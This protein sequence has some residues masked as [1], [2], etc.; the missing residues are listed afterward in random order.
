MAVKFLSYLQQISNNSKGILLALIAAI[1]FASVA[2]MA[3]I[4]SSN[5]HLLQIL[6]FRQ[7]VIL[8][9]TL[10]FIIKA[11]LKTLKTQ[12]TKLHFMR[13]VGAFIALSCGIWAVSALPL[14]T[15]ITLSFSQVFFVALL[16]LYF[17]EEP[18]GWRRLLT[19]LVGFAGVLIVM[20]PAVNGVFNMHSLVPIIGALGA[21]VAVISV[22]KLT[23]TESTTTL[24]VFQAVFVGALAGI[25][26]IWLGKIPNLPDLLFLFTMGSLA[27]IGQWLGVKALQYAEASL[28]GNIQ[29]VKLVFA[30]ILGYFIFNQLPDIYTISGAMIIIAS[31]IFMFY[32]ELLK[33]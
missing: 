24:L 8:L 2:A 3:K 11:P 13:L 33:K 18:V 27:A 1:L 19:I 25:P 23:Q 4:A 12:N 20:R 15:A 9:S 17:L 6:F 30:A 26:L 22:R 28:L 7:F 31:A 32:C 21:A 5:Y 16:A 14:T 29:Y 10:P